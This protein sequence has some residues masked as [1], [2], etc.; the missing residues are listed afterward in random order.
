MTLLSFLGYMLVGGLAAAFLA[1]AVQSFRG[2]GLPLSRTVRLKGRANRIAGV[3]SFVAGSA[4]LVVGG[5]DLV[6]RHIA[7]PRIANVQAPGIPPRKAPPGPPPLPPP[8]IDDKKPIEA[9]VG[10]IEKWGWW[11]NRVVG[12]LYRDSH[13]S[14]NFKEGE[15]LGKPAWRACRVLWAS[16]DTL[17]GLHNPD[18]PFGLDMFAGKDGDQA[19]ED[20]SRFEQVQALHFELSEVSKVGLSTLARLPNL[21]WLDMGSCKADRGDFRELAQCKKLVYLNL[22]SSNVSDASLRAIAQLENLK[23]LYLFAAPISDQGIK[24]LARLKKLEIL[25]LEG[26]LDPKRRDEISDVSLKALVGLK[27]LK[28]LSLH[29]TAVTDEGMK[30]L[31]GHEHLESLTLTLTR[32][33]DRGLDEL[34]GLQNLKEIS[35]FASKVSDQGVARLQA[36]IPILTIKR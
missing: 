19:L 20:I 36:A 15:P 5:Y 2:E 29:A 8:K 35:L 26:D 12:W 21:E 1:L 7:T 17:K 14:L 18:A 6:D 34:A 3:I 31:A 13:G 33:T 28:S 16:L 24:E 22:G 11:P 9:V 4:I 32:I 23:E 27:H 10:G 25:S 30:Y